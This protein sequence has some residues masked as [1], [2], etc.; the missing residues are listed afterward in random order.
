[1]DI[2][3]KTS[4]ENTKQILRFLTAGSVDDGKSTLLGR[5]LYDSES[6]FEDQIQQIKGITK[7]ADM[8]IDLALFTDGLKDEIEQGITIDVAY[9]FFETSHRKFIVADTPGHFQYTKNMITGASTANVILVLID[10]TKGLLDQTKRHLIISSI[11]NIEH[12]IICV[13]KMDL[14]EEKQACFENITKECE[15]FLKDLSYKSIHYIP[16]SA[17]KGDNVV[18]KSETMDWYGRGSLLE[19]L[20]NIDITSSSRMENVRIPIQNVIRTQNKDMFRGYCGEIVEGKL[21]RGQRIKLLPSGLETKVKAIHKYN[22]HVEEAYTNEAVT[23]ELTDKLDLSRGEIIVSGNEPKVVDKFTATL[24]W[25]DNNPGSANTPYII[26]HTT[27]T[28]K[29]LISKIQYKINIDDLSKSKVNNITSNDIV[30]VDIETVTPL[31]I[32]QFSE[33][34]IMGSFILVDE[35]TYNTIAAGMIL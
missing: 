21:E 26:L 9:R 12:L 23:I 25:L 33:N 14:I 29:C 5:L 2:F 30:V 7:N 4:M 27:T 28:Q 13:N 19:L 3:K 22:Q 32:D 10:A 1:M 8:K 18:H 24:C 17:L 11:L 20:E 16:I 34:K 6:I 35:S 31:V 15:L